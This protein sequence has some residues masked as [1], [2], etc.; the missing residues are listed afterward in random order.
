[1]KTANKSLSGIVM[2]ALDEMAGEQVVHTGLSNEVIAKEIAR[3]LGSHYVKTRAGWTK[4]VDAAV[5]RDRTQPWKS[6]L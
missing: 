3:V 5:R 2:K 4:V 1:M 6:R